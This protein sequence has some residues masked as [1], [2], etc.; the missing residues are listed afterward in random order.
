MLHF[1]SFSLLFLRIICSLINAL[2][3]V[4]HPL[5]VNELFTYSFSLTLLSLSINNFAKL[6]GDEFDQPIR[7]EFPNENDES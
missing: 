5:V 2:Q 3:Q 6:I 4:F 7:G 1:T